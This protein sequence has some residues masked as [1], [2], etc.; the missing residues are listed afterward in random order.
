VHSRWLAQA[1][2]LCERHPEMVDWPKGRGRCS[3]T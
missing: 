2:R 3:P 1:P